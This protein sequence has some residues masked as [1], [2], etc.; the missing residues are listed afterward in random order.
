MSTPGCPVGVVAG[1]A[2]GLAILVDD[3]LVIGRTEKLVI[4]RTEKAG[5]S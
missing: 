1:N 3:E 4:R 2:L 5:R